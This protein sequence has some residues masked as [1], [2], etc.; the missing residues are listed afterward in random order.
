MKR[1]FVLLGVLLLLAAIGKTEA[2][3]VSEEELYRA[4]GADALDGGTDSDGLWDSVLSTLKTALTGGAANAVKY[5]AL[6]VSALLVISVAAS[7]ERARAEE[8]SAALEFVAAAVLA[9][10]SFPALYSAFD[11]ASSAIE[12][13]CGFAAALLPVTA[14]LYTMGGNGAQAVAA[15]GGLE[16]FLSVTELVNAKLLLPLLSLGTA[17]AL[18]GLLP[19]NEYVSPAA[20]IVKNWVCIGIAFVFSLVGYVFYFQSAVAVASDNLGYRAVRFASGTFIPVIGNA[21][22]D[23]ARTVFGAVSAVKASVGTLGLCTMLAYLLPPL[24]SVLLY[25]LALSFCALFAR[26]C[27]LERQGRFIGELNSMLGACLAL[28]ISSGAVFTV[29]SAVFL[30]SG[31]NV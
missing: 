3:A 17:L 31:V 10:A 6:I 22:G 9:A 24:V 30:K 21:V 19:G 8:S 4:S 7:L 29:I 14:S 23:S 15:S 2:Y 18:V 11:Y 25:R 26:L 13:F 5:G 27:G 28:L 16:L 20:S 12:S 1:F